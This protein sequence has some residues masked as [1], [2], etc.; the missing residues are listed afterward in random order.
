MPN[1]FNESGDLDGVFFA[2]ADMVSIMKKRILLAIPILF[3][4]CAHVNSS[5]TPELAI[6]IE[7]KQDSI[8]VEY[9]GKK[10][11]REAVRLG[12]VTSNGNLFS[13][14]DDLCVDAKK[15]AAKLGGD[16]ILKEISGVKEKVVYTP[17]TST[18]TSKSSKKEK[19]GEKEVT[20]ESKGVSQHT[21]SRPWGVFSVWAYLPSKIGLRTDSEYC[22]KGFLL[23]SSAQKAGVQKGDR[24]LGIDGF[25]IDD[26]HL[27]RH[28][29]RVLPGET[30]RLSLL[31]DG[32]RIERS[33]TAM[34]ND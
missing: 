14:F 4:S 22:V 25:D 29:M 24:L 10:P 1:E 26:D 33:I 2:V 7:P 30:V 3:A 34:R 31:R 16:F 6:Q 9:L 8:D 27:I 13:G 28:Q 20:H 12:T 11:S 23:S 32:N 18:Y 21:E 17:A 15:Q 19:G 5:Y